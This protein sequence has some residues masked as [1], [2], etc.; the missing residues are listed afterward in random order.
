MFD[1]MFVVAK[2]LRL[3]LVGR[4]YSQGSFPFG[5]IPRGDS[6]CSDRRFFPVSTPAYGI[7]D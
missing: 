6:N 5:G 2:G 1:L 3:S 7:S 4:S